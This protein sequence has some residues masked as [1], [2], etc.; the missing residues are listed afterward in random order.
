MLAHLL[1]LVWK[2]KTRN[3]LLTLEIA[4]AFVLVFAVLAFATRSAQLYRSPLG[5]GFENVWAILLQV[6]DHAELQSRP[7]TLD[8]IKHSLRE[9]PQ[10]ESVALVSYS[11]YSNSAN[12]AGF[13]TVSGKH[14]AGSNVLQ[15]S[16]EY[17]TAMGMSLLEGRW[18]TAADGGTDVVPVVINRRM[19]Q[20]LLAQESPGESAVGKSFV[21]DNDMSPTRKIFRVTG[22]VDSY[23]D[24]GEFMAPV[25][26]TFMRY[27]AGPGGDQ[28]LTVVVRLKAG[29]ARGFEAQLIARLKQLRGHWSFQ[30]APL[31]DLRT[32]KLRMVLV[33]FTVVSIIAAFLLLMVGFGLFGVLWQNTT[34]R[35]PEIGLR[36]A[37]GAQAA[38]IYRQIVAEQLLLSTVAMLLALVLLVQVPLTGALGDELGWG[39]FGVAT[40][41]T[42]AVVLAM[43]LL[44]ALYP[45][46]QASRLEPAAALHHE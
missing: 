30:I 31:T 35:I 26:F 19:A 8:E 10:V 24:G 1:K 44:C 36:R 5:F 7:E 37:V 18:F 9:L 3:L 20:A 15:V 12:G 39:V 40:L 25:N 14:S 22:V 33:P 27:S 41:L 29:T 2:R 32:D 45:G 11:P 42:M 43:S 46:W 21:Y 17:F 4:L 13:S 23:R 38:Q 6:P 16:D 28:P 34:Q